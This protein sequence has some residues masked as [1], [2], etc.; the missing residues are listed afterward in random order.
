MSLHVA[1]VRRLSGSFVEGSQPRTSRQA[2]RHPAGSAGWIRIV[3]AAL[4]RSRH[5]SGQPHSLP[6]D[7]FCWCIGKPASGHSRAQLCKSPL[8]RSTAP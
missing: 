1:S 8:L 2:A 3:T 5:G 7:S 4:A 6:L